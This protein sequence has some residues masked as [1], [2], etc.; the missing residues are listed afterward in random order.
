MLDETALL[1]C[2]A[3]VDL[4]PI[5]AAI[6][7]TIE[8]SDYT[9]AQQRALAL[10]AAVAMQD[11]TTELPPTEHSVSLSD[12]GG[13]P[14]AQSNP[15]SRPKPIARSLSP[16]AIDERGTEIGACCHTSGF[17][18]SDKGFLAMSEAS[19]LELL[20][21]T[22]RHIRSDKRGATPASCLPI[23]KRL[24]IDAEIWCEVTR[25]F[26]KLFS[27]VAGKPKVIQQARSRTRQQRYKTRKRALELLTS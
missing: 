22:A 18:A 14:S 20:D 3:Y 9:S 7:Q 13:A 12:A 15:I 11:E 25:D 19:Y 6:A 4:N 23:F 24:G 17:R 2:A 8:T 21:W 10:Q 27:T 26:G 16:V 1:A 5:R